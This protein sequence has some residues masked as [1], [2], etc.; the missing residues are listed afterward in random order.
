[1]TF[2]KNAAEMYDIMRKYYADDP[3]FCRLTWHRPCRKRTDR[4]EM[5]KPRC[6]M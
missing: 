2:I 3:C 4:N 1:M 5:N 6:P